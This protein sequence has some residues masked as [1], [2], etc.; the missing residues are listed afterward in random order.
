MSLVADKILPYQWLLSAQRCALSRHTQRLQSFP[1]LFLLLG[2]D[3]VN[4]QAKRKCPVLTYTAVLSAYRTAPASLPPTC[5]LQLTGNKSVSALNT[6]TNLH[7]E[8]CMIGCLYGLI[9]LL[10]VGSFI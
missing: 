3:L 2:L 4:F 10:G 6:Y 9:C 5:R 7:A 1:V 8:T